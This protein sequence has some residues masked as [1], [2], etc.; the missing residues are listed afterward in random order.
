MLPGG[1][2]GHGLGD[3]TDPNTV[4]GPGPGSGSGSV[5]GGGGTGSGSGSGRL[6]RTGFAIG[7]GPVVAGALVPAGLRARLPRRPLPG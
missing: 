2:T 1:V 6:P 4:F 7:A 3:A 5:S